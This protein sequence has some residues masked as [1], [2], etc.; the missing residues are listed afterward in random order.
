MA[1]FKLN[2]L[3]EG[4]EFF[5]FDVL[6]FYRLRNWKNHDWKNQILRIVTLDLEGFLKCN[7][8]KVFHKLSGKGT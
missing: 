7:P 8:L 2:I 1:D 3:K 4:S 6:E 5:K